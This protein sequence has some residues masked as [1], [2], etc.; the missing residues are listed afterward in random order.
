MSKLYDFQTKAIAQ[1]LSGKKIIVSGTGSGKTAM[2]V[3]WAEI[4]CEETDKDKILVITTASKAKTNDF[5]DE[6]E[7]WCDKSFVRRL[8]TLSIISW[9]KLAAWVNAHWMEL[10]DWIIIFD[11][12]QR[13]KAGVNSGMGRAFLKI[14]KKNHDWAGFTGTPGDTWIDFYAYFVS[15]GFVRNRVGKC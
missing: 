2:A 13:G 10:E 15:C 9:H 12:I 3:K 6:F 8:K 11:E 7:T 5:Q 1:L 14:A 4:K